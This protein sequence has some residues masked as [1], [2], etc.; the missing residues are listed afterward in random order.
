M[1]DSCFKNYIHDKEDKHDRWLDDEAEKLIRSTNCYYDR[2]VKRF[3][4]GINI[5]VPG[6]G[7][8]DFII[9][10]PTVKKVF[11]ADCKHLLSRFDM[12][13]QK[14]D[15][16]AFVVGSKK[17]KPYNETMRRKVEWFNENKKALA[18]HFTLK[19]WDEGFG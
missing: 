9:V 5:N 13:N 16:N 17:T 19:Y 7:E 6:L 8:V 2:N 3:L 15:F 14:N 11:I 10:S 4:N 12:V 18:E 1:N